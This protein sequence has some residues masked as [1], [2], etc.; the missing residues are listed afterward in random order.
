MGFL[1]EKV[2]ELK[3]LQQALSSRPYSTLL[4]L[5]LATAYKELGYPDLAV[6]DAYKALLLIDE[7]NE[8]AEF[9]DEA[10]TAA[11]ADLETPDT[12]Q[13]TKRIRQVLI[14]S[15]SSFGHVQ[16]QEVDA[17]NK[18][19]PFNLAKRDWSQLAYERGPW[20]RFRR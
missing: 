10:L 13:I 5:Q 17:P 4:R 16:T 15:G 14:E 20:Q 9:H 19:D 12:V 6:G 8:D 2:A 7:L 1:Q 3:K 11:K 18:D